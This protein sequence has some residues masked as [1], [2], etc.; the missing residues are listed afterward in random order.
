M[1]FELVRFAISLN[2]E[3]D[4]SLAPDLDNC[5][6]CSEIITVNPTM[7]SQVAKILMALLDTTVEDV[8]IRVNI[9]ILML[10]DLIIGNNRSSAIV[11]AFF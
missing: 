4:A 9:I 6:L 2:S 8:L 1:S 3:R 5:R 11:E 10:L 7:V